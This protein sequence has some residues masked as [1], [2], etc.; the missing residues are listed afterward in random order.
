[1]IVYVPT[2]SNSIPV[3]IGQ[4]LIIDPNVQE[5]FN[6]SFN[7]PNLRALMPAT[8]AY[9]IISNDGSATY[10]RISFAFEINTLMFVLY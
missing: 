10:V 7:K 9:T 2:I 6:I 3:I 8:S 4:I 5:N 1:M